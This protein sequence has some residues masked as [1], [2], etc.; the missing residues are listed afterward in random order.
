MNAD[1]IRHLYEYHFTLN[2]KFWHFCIENLTWKQLTG[3]DK[4]SVGS[5]R[6]QF[7]H[8]MSVDERWFRGLHGKPDTGVHNPE[9]FKKPAEIR[10]KW[11]LVE[12]EMRVYLDGLTDRDLEKSFQDTMKVWNVLYHVVNHGTAHRA[13]IGARLRHLE[14][15]PPP[16]DYIFYVMG[17]L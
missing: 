11:D 16:Q 9:D 17:R 3:I 13:Q 4:I 8:I 5:I 15:K 7:V 12:A 1:S 6:N 10:M 2:R 14:L